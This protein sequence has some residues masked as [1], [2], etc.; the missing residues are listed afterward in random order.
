MNLQTSFDSLIDSTFIRVKGCLVEKTSGGY[1]YHG[2]NYAT[3]TDAEKAINQSF[4]NLG[5]SIKPKTNSYE[6]LNQH[7]GTGGLLVPFRSMVR[8]IK[9]AFKSIS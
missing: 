6:L 8:K 1:N 9:Q 3:I 4:E 5:N 2:R 7:H